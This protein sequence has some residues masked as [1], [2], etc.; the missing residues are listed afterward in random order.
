MFLTSLGYKYELDSHDVYFNDI[1]RTPEKK[2]KTLM[3]VI[4][5]PNKGKKPKMEDPFILG[6]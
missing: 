4:I 1:R 3:R 5:W 6:K 2:L